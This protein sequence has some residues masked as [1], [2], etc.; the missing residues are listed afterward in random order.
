MTVN[1]KKPE[2]NT[3]ITEAH[4]DAD[5]GDD[6]IGGILKQARLSKGKKLPEVAQTLCIR[7]AYLEAIEAN[8]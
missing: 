2:K 4:A 8:D 1:S 7:K 5:K 3:T 6:K